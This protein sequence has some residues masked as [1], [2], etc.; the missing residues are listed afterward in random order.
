MRKLL[1]C[2]PGVT[3]S[4]GGGQTECGIFTGIRLN[5]DLESAPEKLAS[6]GRVGINMQIKIVDEKDNEAPSGVA[7]E[8]CVRGEG[9]MKGYWNKPEESAGRF[10]VDGSTRV[11]SA[12]WTRTASRTMWTGRRI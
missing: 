12:G 4:N 6:A 2:F 7:G 11:M 9:V 1:D 10:E 5:N 8:L 3:V